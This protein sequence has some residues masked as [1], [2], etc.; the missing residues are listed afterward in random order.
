MVIAV[1][2]QESPFAT[3]LDVPSLPRS[4]PPMGMPGSQE[5]STGRHFSVSERSLARFGKEGWQEDPANTVELP[6]SFVSLSG[7]KFR[8]KHRA[9]L[10]RLGASYLLKGRRKLV[11]NVLDNPEETG[12]CPDHDTCCGYGSVNCES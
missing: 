1:T 7:Q 8:P 11:T 9:A 4:E 5:D 3:S 12:D 6:P 10:R 2:R